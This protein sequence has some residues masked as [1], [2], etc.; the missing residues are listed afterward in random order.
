MNLINWWPSMVAIIC[1]LIAI[2]IYQH[3]N[4]FEEGWLK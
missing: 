4:F 3:T 2:V 1:V